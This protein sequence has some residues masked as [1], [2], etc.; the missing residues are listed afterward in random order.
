MLAPAVGFGGETTGYRLR[1][2]DMKC[3][4]VTGG[5]WLPRVETNRIA[6]VRCDLDRCEETGRIDNFRK[7]ARREKQTFKGIPWDDSDVFKVIEGA[8]Y[9]LAIHPD[10]NWRNTWTE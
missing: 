5:F 6:T 9:T 1:P 7:A 2:A 3:V 8:A 10:R 4:K